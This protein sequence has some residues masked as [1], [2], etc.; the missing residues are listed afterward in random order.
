MAKSRSIRI[1]VLGV[2]VLALVLSGCG[3]VDSETTADGIYVG[4]TL[5]ELD[6]NAGPPTSEINSLGMIQRTY[7]GKKTG[8]KYHVVIEDD[9]VQ[10]VEVSN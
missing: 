4:A 9:R 7:K 2:S 3:T 1:G 5:E 10:Q 6:K 8:K